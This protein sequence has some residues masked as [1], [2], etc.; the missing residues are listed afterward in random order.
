MV[1]HFNLSDVTVLVLAAFVP[2]LWFLWRKADV[3]LDPR[4]PPIAL[5]KIPFIGHIIGMIR[6]QLGY[7]EILR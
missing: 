6:Y 7:F 3:Q 2:A 1:A 4:E 5:P